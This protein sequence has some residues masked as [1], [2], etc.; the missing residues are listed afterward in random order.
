M[1]RDC[2]KVKREV[3]TYIGKIR[4]GDLVRHQGLI[5]TVCGKDLRF[6]RFI[7]ATLFGDSYRSGVK[8]VTKIILSLGIDDV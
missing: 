3:P 1:R 7:G 8:P 5:K 6:D 4:V 2:L